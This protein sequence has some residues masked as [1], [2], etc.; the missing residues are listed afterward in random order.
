MTQ[1]STEKKEPQP[2][3]GPDTTVKKR[4]LKAKLKNGSI[5]E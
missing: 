4:E 1:D 3:A 5:K 2:Q